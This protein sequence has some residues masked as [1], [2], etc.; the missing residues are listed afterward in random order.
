MLW[1][2]KSRPGSTTAV[3]GRV[4]ETDSTSTLLLA[5]SY[6]FIQILNVHSFMNTVRSDCGK[7]LSRSN[8]TFLK[9]D[10]IM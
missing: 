5:V 10:H 6:F 2:Q 7:G 9:L 8:S 4:C 1:T 3:R